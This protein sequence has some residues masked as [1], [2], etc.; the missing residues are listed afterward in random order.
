[1]QGGNLQKIVKHNKM[2]TVVSTAF[3]RNCIK[4]LAQ[5]ISITAVELGG[6]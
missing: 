2:Q 4:A 3:K 6:C 1:M 5:S